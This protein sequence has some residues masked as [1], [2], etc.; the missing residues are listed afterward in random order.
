MMPELVIDGGNILG[1]SVCW[2]M[3]AQEIRWIDGFA[4]AIHR[5]SPMTG[6]YTV[7]PLPAA[8]IGMIVQTSDPSVVALTD[9]AGIGL[10]DLRTRTRTAIAD[11]ERGRA[12]I[13]YNDAKVDGAGRLW[14]GTYDGSEIE[15]RG[16]LWVLANGEAP[17]LAD[18]GMAVVNGPAFSRASDVV[19]VSD[20]TAKRILAHEMRDGALAGRRVFAQLTP[21]EGLPDG[22]T[23]DAAGCLW[24]AHWD[25][26]RV[27][28]F[29]PDGERLL[30]I[31]LPAM[32]VTSVA[33]GGAGLDELFITT[34]RYGLSE[35]QLALTPQ[36]GGLFRVKTRTQGLA[37]SLLPLPFDCK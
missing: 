33:F 30:V 12:G 6:G 14:V 28:Q 35:E 1:E 24:C 2:S 29:S 20:S 25:G 22:L 11:P 21:E 27:T 31:R 17:R 4:P 13:G 10:F 18:S 37:A 7:V 16:C 8:P 5:W 9:G 34:A 23:V 36:A 32:R 19:Y 3:Q 15:P 26:G